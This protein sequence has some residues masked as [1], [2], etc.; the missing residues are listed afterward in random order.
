[1]NHAKEYGRAIHVDSPIRIMTCYALCAAY[2]ILFVATLL[3]PQ[4]VKAEEA[5]SS[6]SKMYHSLEGAGSCGW[7][8]ADATTP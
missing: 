7:F 4:M 3:V 5:H 1:M 8:I 6:S 2:R